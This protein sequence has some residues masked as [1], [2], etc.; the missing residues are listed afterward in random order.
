MTDLS[1]YSLF[2]AE[3]DRLKSER[4][5]CW[6]YSAP[7]HETVAEH[8]WHA[9]LL[10]LV[11]RDLTPPGVDPHHV[12]DLLTVHDLVEVYAGD[13]S[14]WD[15]QANLDADSREYAAGEQL[16]ALLPTD[17][18]P[19]TWMNPLW[20]EFQ[21]QETTAAQFAR[22]IDSIHPMVCSWSTGSVGH[23]LPLTPARYLHS[24][25]RQAL[26]RFPFIGQ[27]SWA[28]VRNAVD[29]GLMPADPAL[30]ISEVTSAESDLFLA[31]LKFM[32][33][34]D[35]L[36]EER[37]ANHVLTESRR[38]SVAEHC[39]HTTLLAMLWR[40][41]APPDVDINR[42]LDLL[43]VHD[44]VEVYAGDIDV[45]LDPDPAIVQRDEEAASAR[46]LALL[47]DHAARDHLGS[48]IHEYLA[49]E[50]PH[51]RFA[52]AIDVMHPAIM[53]WGPGSHIHPDHLVRKP[54]A[55]RTRAR[56]LPWIA[57]FPPMVNLLERF[58]EIAHDRGE[59]GR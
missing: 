13:T 48:L 23:P 30:E 20:Q 51:A 16:F 38:E 1:Q 14:T 7:R 32:T 24:R 18:P 27:A 4:R 19:F 50:T 35:A 9:T 8:V 42:V 3:T 45:G 12:R 54:V 39:W 59:L 52:R 44:L 29:H 41:I 5:A 40:E 33:A 2:F 26:D 34:T 15:E 46:L 57:P 31:R 37:R 17:S 21:A 25:K 47:P 49:L 10:A 43:V 58:I 36:K 55:S 22:A 53:T 56:K 28:L 6:L 11:N